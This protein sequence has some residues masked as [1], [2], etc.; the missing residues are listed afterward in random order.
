[1]KFPSLVLLLLSPLPVLASG[2]VLIQPY[3]LP[4]VSVLSIMA[5]VLAHLSLLRMRRYQLRLEQ[6]EERLRL[7]LWGSGDEL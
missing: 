7:S 6:S 1:M 3:L 5:L 2:W 4:V